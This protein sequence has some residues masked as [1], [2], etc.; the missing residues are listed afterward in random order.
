MK[1]S[2]DLSEM[3]VQYIGLNIHFKRWYFHSYFDTQIQTH[4]T[5]VL[6]IS[7]LQNNSNL[8]SIN[9][10]HIN[11]CTDNKTDNLTITHIHYAKVMGIVKAFILVK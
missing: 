8:Y 1:Q 9:D 10:K 5:S 7:E 3:L 6:N 4:V 2:D 11:T